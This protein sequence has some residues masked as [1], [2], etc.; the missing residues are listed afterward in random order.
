MG[1]DG[2]YPYCYGQDGSCLWAEN[3]WNY[4]YT[5]EDAPSTG[6][7]NCKTSYTGSNPRTRYTAGNNCNSE[8]LA[9]WETF[10]CKKTEPNP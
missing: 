1:R 4:C 8:S 5:D 2:D 10:A 9:P 6:K 3:G 7:V